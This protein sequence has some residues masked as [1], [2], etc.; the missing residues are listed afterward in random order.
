MRLWKNLLVGGV[1]LGFGLLQTSAG[2]QAAA[3]CMSDA[4]LKAYS[5]EALSVGLDQFFWSCEGTYGNGLE[6]HYPQLRVFRSARKDY[7]AALAKTAGASRRTLAVE[8][9]ERKFPGQG[10]AAF[11]Q[12]IGR[13]AQSYTANA[14]QTVATCKLQLENWARA[15]KQFGFEQS[16]TR[17]VTLAV[18]TSEALG[19]RPLPKCR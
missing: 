10:A 19:R 18:A 15:V 7:E 6:S 11:Q 1:L 3:L 2:L 13:D 8:P 4:E 14:K 9:F 17:F 12:N 5:W 16:L